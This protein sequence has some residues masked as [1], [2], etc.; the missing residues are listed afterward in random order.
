MTQPA[1]GQEP[2]MEEILASI[3]RIIA[4]EPAQPSRSG[5][6][7]TAA[8]RSDAPRGNPSPDTFRREMPREELPRNAFAIEEGR[9]RES[10]QSESARLDAVQKDPLQ[11]EGRSYEN[12]LIRSLTN[13]DVSQV[14]AAVPQLISGASPLS[15]RTPF[16]VA[17]TPP[18]RASPLPEPD[19][20]KVQEEVDAMLGK[21]NAST[22]QARSV[23]QA[24]VPDKFEAREQ[25]VGSVAD[26]DIHD[27]DDA[28]GEPWEEESSGEAGKEVDEI[29]MSRAVA[30]P[31]VRSHSQ[32][33]DD[34]RGHAID[35]DRVSKGY[36][37]RRTV[38]DG[39]ISAA[40]TAA[41][42]SAFNSLAQ[43]VLVQNGPT[44]EDLV[45]QMLRP[46]LKT[47][48]DNNLPSLVERLVRA[49]IERV[50]RGR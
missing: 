34:V 46:M 8:A 36:P 5:A 2:S 1:K 47:W 42:D 4:D 30:E 14:Q 7:H 10:S 25:I 27:P 20:E 22:L 29:G 45:R 3:R 28:G 39:L 18:L 35:V 24:P 50:S 37:G 49:E 15:A 6:A 11:G 32:L 33:H 48:L 13:Q 44:L 12:S 40:T 43:T 41:V 21:L 31:Q 17:A 23:A 9:P 26:N 38:E 19:L 16:E